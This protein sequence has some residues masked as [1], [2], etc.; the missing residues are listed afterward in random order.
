MVPF[1]PQP[2]RP[3]LPVHRTNDRRDYFWPVVAVV[4]AADLL[5]KLMAQALIPRAYTAEVVGDLFRLTLVH[6]PGAAFGLYLGPWSRWAFLIIAVVAIVVLVRMYWAT[7]RANQARIWA[8]ALVTGGAASN[9]L[10]RLWSSRGVVDFIDIGSGNWRWPAF[11]LADI[12]I[13][14]G[15]ILLAWTLWRED[16]RADVPAA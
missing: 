7:S 1:S 4:A 6:N 15:A 8:L 14:I 3:T 16:R 11:N 9:A 12:A 10:N 13:S 5:T 2:D